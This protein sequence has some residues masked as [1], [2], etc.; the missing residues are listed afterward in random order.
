MLRFRDLGPLLVEN[1]GIAR[2]VGGARLEAALGLLLIHADRPVS[3]DALIDAVWGDQATSRSASTLDSHIFRLRRRLEPDRSAG[4]VAAVVVREPGGYRLAVRPDQV[5]SLLLAELADTAAGLLDAGAAP[6]AL[7]AAEAGIALWRGRPLG[8]QADREWALAAVARAEQIRGALRQTLA[9]ALLATGAA[10][11]ALAEL[12]VMLAEE[13]LRERLWALRIA[14]FRQTGRRSD[15]LRAY[16][17]ARSVLVGE[18]G[19]EPGAELQRLHARLLDDEP[20]PSAEPALSAPPPPSLAASS[21]R[22]AGSA[23]GGHG[24]VGRSEE[25]RSLL[26]AV[27]PGCMVT[28]VGPAGCGKT[29]L[30]LEIRRR[31]AGNFEH[32]ICFVD[33]MAAAPGRVLDTITSGLGLPLG[34]GSADPVADLARML[35]GRRLLLILDNCEHVLDDVAELVEPLLD[36]AGVDAPSLLAT[37]R[38]PLGVAGEDLF[39]LEPLPRADAAELLRERL[40]AAGTPVDL[41]D[42]TST[43]AIAEIV[44]AVDGLPLALELAAGRARAYTLLEIA[45][46]VR[47]DA[48]TLSRVG[49]PR[50]ARHHRTVF[51]AVD[52]SYRDLPSPAAALHRAASAVPGPFTAELAAGLL[53]CTQA[54]VADEIAGLVHRSL[55]SP[56]APARA[57]GSTRFAQL[58]IV[59]GHAVQ[60]ARRAGEEPAQVRDRW[61]ERLVRRRPR[62]GSSAQATWFQVLEDD[63]AALRATLQ[64]ILVDSPAGAGPG[65]AARLGF[66]WAFNGMPIEGMSWLEAADRSPVPADT[67]ADRVLLDLALACELLVRGEL[68]EGRDRVRAGLAGARGA[69][70][71]DAVDIAEAIAVLTG[72]LRVVGDAVLLAEAADTVAGLATDRQP[73]EIIVRHTRLIRDLV[74]SPGDDLVGP[75][76]QLHDDAR[77]ADNH[78]AAWSAAAAAARLLLRDGRHREA[79]PVARDALWATVRSG[80]RTNIFVLEIYGTALAL[81]GDEAGALRVFGAAEAQH[82]GTGRAWPPNETVAGMLAGLAAR[83]GQDAVDQARSAGVDTTVAHFVGS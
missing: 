6:E 4:R 12:E 57:Q 66:F 45:G 43:L 3:T 76:R 46:Q 11:R 74:A 20:A 58:A 16:A 9:G 21:R 62:L 49:R 37:S 33:L 56:R 27:R 72:P 34:T 81:T 36:L 35:A 28:V 5:D 50:G 79:L 25:T 7:R 77:R 78:H 47:T 83:L 18:L 70:G 42:P 60:V 52:T 44:D 80:L 64:H 15:A 71:A 23:A 53:G 55:L 73:L 30:A 19:L 22:S 61:I 54:A 39:W 82:G 69:T 17:D 26:S 67:V 41:D 63:L 10:D 48:G 38:E 51:D 75:L 24:L 68:V 8:R 13:P 32:G 14:A 40:A 65:I 29:R 31:A 2:P 59:R 1:D